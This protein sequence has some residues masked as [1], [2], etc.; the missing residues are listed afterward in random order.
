MKNI[1]INIF[2]KLI[3]LLL[4][5]FLFANYALADENTTNIV[6]GN[7]VTENVVDGNSTSSNKVLTL[8]EQ[9]NQVKENLNKARE[10]LEFVEDEISLSVFQ[11]QTLEQ[12]ISE[13]Q[14]ELDE[15]NSKYQDLQNKV[16]EMQ[17][18]LDE[19]QADYD[20]KND[21]LKQ[22]LVAWYKRGTISYLDVL[23]NSKDIIDFISRYYTIKKITEYD[24]KILDEINDKKNIIEK[25]TNELKE[26]KANMKLI[27]AQAEEQTVV[28]TNTKTI[29]ENQKSSLTESEQ[30]IK[31]E[32][33]AYLKQQEELENLIQYTIY[34]S[35][36][37]LQ[38]V[39]GIMI[40]PTLDTSYITSAF[41]SRLHPI[42]GIVKNHDGIDIG[43]RMGDPVYAA[44]D[45]VIIYSAYNTGGYGNMVMI[46][47]GMNEQGIKI[48]TLYG[49]GSELV[50]N[51]GDVVT[52]GDVIM[53]VGSTGNSTGPHVHFEVRENGV[54]VDPRTY[55]SAQT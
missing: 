43:G 7:N 27:K 28:L 53:K 10:Q 35:T 40:W 19:V 16:Q 55:L 44:S 25:T 48:V 22:R 15:V 1:I 36:Y 29:V 50:K 47:H 5:I 39:G 32:I 11:I 37:E 3:V 34:G 38:Y 41:G 54:A 42:Q 51:V 21:L 24:A 8:Q 31:S 30:K 46:D 20:K 26:E 2:S 4:I 6:E 33:D 14:A 52:K 18:T 23:L 17:K 12:K 49:H 9:Q 45:G 13:Y